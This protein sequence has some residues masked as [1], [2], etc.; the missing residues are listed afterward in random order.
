MFVDFSIGAATGGGTSTVRPFNKCS[1][2]EVSSW[3]TVNMSGFHLETH[4]IIYSR[5]REQLFTPQTHPV[6]A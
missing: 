2:P 3:L 5:H 6:Y 1:R 4:L